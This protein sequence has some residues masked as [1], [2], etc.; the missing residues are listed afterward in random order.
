MSFVEKLYDS[1]SFDDVRVLVIYHLFMSCMIH[2]IHAYVFVL[3]AAPCSPCWL[4]LAWLGSAWLGFV[5]FLGT[6][7]SV[8]R[9]M[10]SPVAR[11]VGFRVSLL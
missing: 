4:G 3:R 7:Y 1:V 11:Y 5:G 6:K 8:F 10:F 9:W 2:V